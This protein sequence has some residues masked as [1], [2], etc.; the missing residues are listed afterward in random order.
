MYLRYLT[1]NDYNDFEKELLK[2]VPYK[3]DIGG[4]Y[5]HIVKYVE[6]NLNVLH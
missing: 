5:N 3:I 4:V 2:K 1:F 6:F